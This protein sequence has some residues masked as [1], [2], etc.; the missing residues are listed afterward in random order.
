ML[1][2]DELMKKVLIITYY[3]TQRDAIGAVRL[4]GLAKYLYDFEWEATILTPK[5]PDISK[6]HADRQVRVIE[7]GY[8][9]LLVKWKKRLG[10]KLDKSVKEQFGLATYKN[11]KTITD[12]ILNLWGEIFAY[13][14]EQK[15]WFKFAIDAG[16]RLLEKE[17]FDAIISSSS[18]V[19]SHIIANQLKNRHGIPWIADLRDLWTQNNY[20]Q[21][22]PIRRFREKRLE[23]RTLSAAPALVTV[24][25]P[26]AEKLKELHKGKEIYAITNG[27][28]PDETVADFHLSDKFKILYTGVLYQGKRDPEPLFKA[29]QKLISDEIIQ[30]EDIAVDFYGYKEGWL[31][32]D[33]EKYDLQDIVRVQ[34]LIPREEALK[35]QR[36]AQ[37]LLL[38]TWNDPD[39]KGVCPGKIF[40][41]LAARRPI[42]SIGIS[43]GV[44]E[45]LLSETKAGVHAST[46][47]EIE[48]ALKNLYYEFKSSGRVGYNGIESEVNKYSQRE[49]ARKFAELLNN[50]VS[51]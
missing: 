42:F 11:R 40:E 47:E 12:V 43:G 36:E 10:L 23:I 28:D 30:R 16:N 18:P 25:Q 41:Y 20:F 39:E 5:L 26:L 33:I 19:T 38:L 8:E 6:T 3:F 35:K 2:E 17:K 44:V 24:S 45:E 22:N 46:Q 29:I 9:D 51:R 37:V 48:D 21:Y 31:E 32:R 50:M 34:G 15:S 13:P 27:F 49:M 4:R 7:T 14:D 1:K